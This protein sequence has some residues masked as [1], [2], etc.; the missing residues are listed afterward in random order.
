MALGIQIDRVVPF[1]SFPR[2]LQ[3]LEPYEIEDFLCVYKDCLAK[4]PRAQ[5]LAA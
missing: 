5:A 2:G 4:L 1:D 3:R